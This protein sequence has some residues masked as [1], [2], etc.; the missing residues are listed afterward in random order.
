[1][2]LTVNERAIKEFDGDIMD[3]LKK[4]YVPLDSSYRDTNELIDVGKEKEASEEFKLIIEQLTKSLHKCTD[5][6]LLIYA[7]Y[8]DEKENYE[9]IT[10]SIGNICYILKNQFENENED[11]DELHRVLVIEPVATLSIKLSIIF[12]LFVS[13]LSPILIDSFNIGESFLYVIKKNNPDIIRIEG[14]DAIKFLYFYDFI[15][16]SQQSMYEMYH[17]KILEE[18]PIESMPTC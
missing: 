16:L 6:K 17:E 15:K 18:I 5:L 9:V 14:E 4:D 3:L 7:Y 12:G 1:M 10:S 11:N 13:Y 8:R 2:N